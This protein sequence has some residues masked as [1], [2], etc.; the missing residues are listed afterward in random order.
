MFYILNNSKSGMV[1]Q[2]QKLD[3]ISNN[4]A[5]INTHGYKK[6][7]SSFS[8]L[9]YKDLTAR[10]I[11]ISKNSS[12]IGNGVKSTGVTRNRS[13]GSLQ[14]TG[15][16]TDLAIDGNGFFKITD[17]NGQVGYTRSGALNVDI[18]GRLTDKDGNLIEVSYNEGINPVNTG[19]NN[20]NIV[21]DKNGFI[22]TKD[23]QDIGK[24]NLY[25]VAGGGGL[26]SSGDN[27]FIPA[28]ENVNMFQI[29]GEFYQGHLEMSNVDV[30]SEMSDMILAQRAYQL[31]SKGIST[32]DD[33]WAML[34]NIR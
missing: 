9:F 14:V 23:G 24:I 19:L 18:F 27:K 8:S 20:S 3:I 13:Q 25:D 21:I 5:N 2:Q 33:M 1:A 31:A 32:A 16:N 34:N 28:N 12:F 7:D 10:G 17:G 4:M 30:G 22:S 6:V 15:K 29:E 11:P 26:I